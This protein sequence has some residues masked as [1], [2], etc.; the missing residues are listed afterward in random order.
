MVDTDK[1]I[2]TIDNISDLLC[3][4]KEAMKSH[5]YPKSDMD[6]LLNGKS[7]KSHIHDD[8]YYTESEMNSKLA[9]KSDINHTHPIDSQLNSNSDNPVKNSVLK[10]IID[11]KANVNHVHTVDS[12]LNSSS[13]NPVQNKEINRV[14]NGKANINHVHTISN[15][16][17][18]EEDLSYKADKDDLVTV[19]NQWIQE[20]KNPIESRLILAELDRKVDVVDGKGLMSNID[21]NKLDTITEGAKAKKRVPGFFISSDKD[22]SNQ[23][24]IT[25]DQGTRL[26]VVLF[27]QENIDNPS[28][29]YDKINNYQIS[30]VSINYTINGANKT[31]NSGETIGINLDKGT[32]DMLF[33]FNGS[34]DYYQVYRAI[35]LR[36]D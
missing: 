14:L 19:D 30:N 24:L 20:S 34:G 22:S 32:H 7:D 35:K 29:I 5:F 36:I 15:I 27:N 21:K 3:N 23:N 9:S 16:T 11:D 1:L 18:L 8:R 31:V 28:A 33:K 2:D 4:V 6:I 17:G 13:T 10:G 26:K 12:T 25:I